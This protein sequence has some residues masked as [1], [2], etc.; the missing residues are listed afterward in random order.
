MSPIESCENIVKYLSTKYWNI[1]S[2]IGINNNELNLDHIMNNLFNYD[3][4][5]QI[6]QNDPIFAKI[7]DAHSDKERHEYLLDFLKKII[8]NRIHSNDLHKTESE[9]CNFLG[10]FPEEITYWGKR[11]GPH[12]DGNNIDDFLKHHYPF[13]NPEFQHESTGTTFGTSLPLNPEWLQE[14]P[15]S[16]PFETSTFGEPFNLGDNNGGA[17]FGAGGGKKRKSR[18][19][20]TRRKTRTQRRKTRTQRRKTR[21]QR[22]KTRTQ[23]RKTRIKKRNKKRKLNKKSKRK[24]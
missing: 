6:T 8:T 22:R 17:T 11:G 20:K 16:S 18:R 19:R 14:S 4:E 3:G 21:T 7:R 23:R 9:K 10:D 15:S 5:Q 24:R 1:L 12:Y 13:L 2:E